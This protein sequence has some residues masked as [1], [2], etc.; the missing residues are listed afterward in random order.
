M[1]PKKQLIDTAIKD[2]SMERANQLLSAAHLLNCEA[3]NVIEEASDIMLK[4]GLLLGDLKKAHND[5]VKVADRYFSLFASLITKQECKMDMF[6]DLD[7]FD[8]SFRNWA[9]IPPGWMPKE[10]EKSPATLADKNQPYQQN[11]VY[12]INGKVQSI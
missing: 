3:N 2:G 4:K 7:S 5:F 9:K 11:R 8:E 6:N 10:L 1:K 12:D